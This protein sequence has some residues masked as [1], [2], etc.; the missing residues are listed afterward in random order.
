M[1][2][3]ICAMNDQLTPIIIYFD[4]YNVFDI[5]DHYIHA[6]K[7][8]Y[9]VIQGIVHNLLK[10]LLDRNQYIDLDHTHSDIQEYHCGFHKDL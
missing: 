9:Y 10:K 5:L 3:N 6:C 8:K 4:L 1:D 7:L 2:Q